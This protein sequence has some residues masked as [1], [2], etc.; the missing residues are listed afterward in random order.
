MKN[1]SRK[2]RY[3]KSDKY[4]QID[5]YFQE[6]IQLLFN[7]HKD[8]Y[9]YYLID[10]FEHMTYIDIIDFI[11]NNYDIED[12]EDLVEEDEINEEFHPLYRD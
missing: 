2:H 9:N 10:I 5:G 12:I 3:F 6:D 11:Y 4:Q 7:N 8:I 1:Y